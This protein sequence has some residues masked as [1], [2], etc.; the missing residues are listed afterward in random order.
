[1]YIIVIG[2]IY[3]VLMMSI[4]EQSVAAGLMTFI[5][6]GVLPVL[7]IVY[8]AGTP[9]R[10]RRRAASEQSRHDSAPRENAP[11]TRKTDAST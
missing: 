9:E 4:T 1:M 2:W 11:A 7:I 3:V 10:K 5:L 8:I 6:Y